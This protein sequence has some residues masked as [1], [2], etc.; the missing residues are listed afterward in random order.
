[1]YF[2]QRSISTN[3]QFIQLYTFIN[4]TIVKLILMQYFQTINQLL[5]YDS[6][7]YNETIYITQTHH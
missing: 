1:M 3:T 6:Y 4:P 7:V 5:I 2:Q